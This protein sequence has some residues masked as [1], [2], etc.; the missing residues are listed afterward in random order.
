MEG[1]V[2]TRRIA[3]IGAGFGALTAVRELRRRDPDVAISLIAPRAELVYLPSLIWIPAGLRCGQDLRV[4]LHG[5]LA[6]QRVEHVAGRVAGLAAQGR[7]VRLDDGRTVENHGLIIAGGGRFLKTLPGIEHAITL[8][9]GIEAAERI[10]DR[11]AQMEGGTLAFGFAANPVEPQAVRGGPM[12]ELLFGIDTLLRRQGRRD[13]FQLVFFS[14]AARPGERLG[15]RAVDGLLARMARLGI[16]TR[17]GSKLTG[18]AA[19]RVITEAG[20]FAADLI[21]F[22]PGMSGP[23][24]AAESGLTLSPGGMFKADAQARVEGATRVYVA[25]DAGSYPGPDWM[26]KQAHMADLQAVAAA[27]NLL[28]ELA[29]NPPAAD[30]RTELVCII[31]TLDRGMLVYRSERRTLMTPPLRLLHWAK[32]LFERRYLAPYRRRH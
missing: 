15:A 20:E 29:G 16:A 28:A 22:M 18:F 24:W 32:R 19:D 8:C 25:G 1:P 4:D 27:R 7:Q 30:F 31:D 2:V 17:L 9:E 12:F 26:P 23:A 21:L 3:I 11:L 14:P 10:R 5:F 13:R 6:A